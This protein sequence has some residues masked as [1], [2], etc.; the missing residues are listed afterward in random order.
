MLCVATFCL[1]SPMDVSPQRL[2]AMVS[3]LLALLLTVGLNFAHR[4]NQSSQAP[5]APLQ[6]NVPAIAQAP[7]QPVD[8]SNQQA[9][10]A[11]SSIAPS[12]PVGL[13]KQA[14]VKPSAQ[15]ARPAQ[16]PVKPSTQQQVR[17]PRAPAVS[18]TSQA[19]STTGKSE[20]KSEP[21]K[22]DKPASRD[23]Q[24]SSS[25]ATPVPAADASLKEGKDAKESKDTKKADKASPNGEKEGEASETG[26]PGF[27]T[28]KRF[29]L[30]IKGLPQPTSEAE[31][32]SVFGDDAAKVRQRI[33]Y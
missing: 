9:G 4:A 18:A 11:K 14:P 29:S 31:L 3:S 12:A 6:S 16:P 28:P 19:P 7:R 21:A 33:Y 30:Y 25:R 10:P 22:P 5:S 13:Q 26:K 23:G 15:S 27:Q 8:E 1:P 32:R 2:A 20:T 24:K 17:P